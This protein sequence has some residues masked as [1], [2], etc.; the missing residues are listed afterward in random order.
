MEGAAEFDLADLDGEGEVAEDG[1]TDNNG[2]ADKFHSDHCS[3]LCVSVSM[4]FIHTFVVFF[5]LSI[6]S[7]LHTLFWNIWPHNT[8]AEIAW[9]LSLV[10]ILTVAT[11]LMDTL[12]QENCAPIQVF[13]RVD[14]GHEF[15]TK[16]ATETGAFTT[17]V[18]WTQAQRDNRDRRRRYIANP[19]MGAPPLGFQGFL[20]QPLPP[21][22]HMAERGCV[23]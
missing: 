12:I 10:F 6:S 19:Q 9:F 4:L 8:D 17:R 3:D 21:C 20:L 11:A 15:V 14:D 7:A 5:V 18:H 2:Q 23:G 1:T 16:M 22:V 13:L